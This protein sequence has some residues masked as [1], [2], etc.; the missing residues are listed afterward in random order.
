MMISIAP[1]LFLTV[2]G[3]RDCGIVDNSSCTHLLLC[4]ATYPQSACYNIPM[5]EALV[6]DRDAC[7]I[8]MY[9]TKALAQVGVVW[10]VMLI[11]L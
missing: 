10:I 5:L 1:T 2:C 7:A 6:A 11:A 3:L 8:Y 4:Y 9:P